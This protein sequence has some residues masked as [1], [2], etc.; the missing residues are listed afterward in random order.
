MLS[1]KRIDELLD[2]WPVAVLATL[3]ADGTPR[4]VPCVFA[5]S[6]DSLWT[7][8][9]GKR[10]SERELARVSDI[11]R[12]PRVSLLLEKYGED[13]SQLWWIRITAEA[14]VIELESEP[15]AGRFAAAAAA[16]RAKYP[17]YDETPLF[18]ARPTLVEI[19]PQRVSSWASG[20]GPSGA[21]A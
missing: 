7:P 9:D 14:V 18:R 2:R 20:G 3:A 8:I 11:R 16:L 21:G 4:Q 12:D 19:R 13:W 1:R 6:G 15:P 5:R 10:K 17:Q